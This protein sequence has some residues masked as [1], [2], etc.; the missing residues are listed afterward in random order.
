MTNPDNAAVTALVDRYF[1]VW[2]ETDAGRRQALIARTF[3]EDASY[4]D[5]L[6]AGDG[7]DGID[8]MV[9]AVHEKYPGYCFTRTSD[10]N[11]HHDRALFNWQL[12]PKDGPVFVKG[13]DVALVSD[14]GRLAHV[15]GFF[16]ELNAPQQ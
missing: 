2:N 6:L 9:R 7:H 14:D 4:L 12:A 3:A 16:T 10:V 11:A 1:A 15:A 5:P 8:A 13:V